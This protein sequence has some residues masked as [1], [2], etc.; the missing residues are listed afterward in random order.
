[1]GIHQQHS[2]G[3]VNSKVHVGGAADWR[4]RIADSWFLRS[5]LFSFLARIWKEC[6]LVE[7]V[8]MAAQVSFYFALSCFPFLLVLAALLGW[9]HR[10]SGWSSFW[11]WLT[12]YLP[13]NAQ[14]TIMAIIL[15]LSK[16]AKGFLSFGLLMTIWSASSGFLSL[17]D[18]LT[19]VYGG[20][21]TRSY[22]KRR[23]IAIV[24]TIFAAAFLV[25]CFGLLSVGHVMAAFALHYDF[26]YATP[27]KFGRWAITLLLLLLCMDLMNYFFPAKRPRWRLFM[28]G[29]VLSV[30]CFVL[31]STILKFYVNHNQS[32][33]SVYG[34][35]T[36]FIVIMLWIYLANLSVLLGAQT[37][38]VL[39]QLEGE[40]EKNTMPNDT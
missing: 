32:M 23:V 16:G 33:S 6:R 35:L 27:W 22:A 31:A 24:A 9:F 2:L 21:E 38:A 7:A 18:A 36:G 28:P 25:M 20:K 12:N 37:D 40:P 3:N 19:H 17:M 14:V 15:N 8:D 29:S 10:T 11:Y 5:K 4:Q 26:Y 13:P 39:L 1:M 30:L 34:T